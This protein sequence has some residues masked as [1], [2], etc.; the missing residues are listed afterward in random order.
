[1]FLFEW[2]A[3]KLELN[4]IKVIRLW[5]L[6]FIISGLLLFQYKVEL[7]KLLRKVQSFW[8]KKEKRNVEFWNC[9]FV[10][11]YCSSYSGSAF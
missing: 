1:M 10:L 4:M 8:I 6:L 11:F 5:I 3:Y 7:L 9:L 2:N